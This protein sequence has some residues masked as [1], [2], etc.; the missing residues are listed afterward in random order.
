MCYKKKI[1]RIEEIEGNGAKKF[2]L[3]FADGS[4]SE[5]MSAAR[6]RTTHKEGKKKTV[7]FMR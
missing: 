1:V 3:H 6:S 4:K 2:I 7:N 5:E